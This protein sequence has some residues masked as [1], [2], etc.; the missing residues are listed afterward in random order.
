MFKGI[1]LRAENILITNVRKF[2]TNFYNKCLYY[3]DHIVTAWFCTIVTIWLPQT[4]GNVR[5][6]AVLQLS[7]P[8]VVWGDTD[9]AQ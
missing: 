1:H 7:C 5:A 4:S 6:V 3:G 2:V 9:A 8:L